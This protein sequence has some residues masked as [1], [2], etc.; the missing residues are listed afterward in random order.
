[1]NM[2]IKNKSNYKSIDY[3]YS[4]NLWFIFS[5]LSI[6]LLLNGC[7]RPPGAEDVYKIAAI[8]PMTGTDPA[9]GTSV[10]NGA[11]LAVEEA[12]E[13]GGI[14]GKKIV[15]IKEDDGGLVGEGSFFAYRLTRTEMVLGVVGHVD[16]DISIPASE[17][18]ANAMIVQ[19]SPGSTVPYFTERKDVR[20]YVFRTI[21]RD[22]TQGK[23][24]VD[25]IIKHGFKK[26]ALLYSN[27]E[28]GR[29]LSG[30]FAR[31][32]KAHAEAN[33]KSNKPEIVFYSRIERGKPDYDSLLTQI[34]FSKPDVVVLA[35]EYND[36]GNL[37]RGFPKYGLTNVQF[38]GGD[39]VYHDEFIRYGGKNT[40]GALVISAPPIQD[41]DFILRYKKRFEQE[42]TGYTANA[43]DA[44]NILI[45]AIKQVKE[46]DSDKIAKIVAATQ[47]F[48]GVTGKISFN[49]DGDLTTLGF[50]F[51]KVINGKFVV[52][53]GEHG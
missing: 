9:L 21:G 42:P 27:R 37:V 39:G 40:E 29:S 17:F 41:E 23:M 22:D 34:S 31:S 2:K 48:K 14:N 4:K 11:E 47:N 46:K 13:K 52:V 51:N 44:T 53:K 28:Y 1:M 43:Y 49:K 24:I 50:V 12:N 5:L 10:I 36:G 7:V 6:V 20:G 26:I 19:I 18:Y 16:S 25:Y 8:A 32:L 33:N 3:G 30:E 35:G 38:I 45:E 15:L